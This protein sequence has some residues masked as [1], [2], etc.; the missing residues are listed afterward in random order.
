MTTDVVD[1]GDTENMAKSLLPVGL[2]SEK[3]L[4][5]LSYIICSFTVTEACKLAKV[6]HKTVECWRRDD[7]GFAE[8]E[9]K[10]RSE[11]RSRMS[12][13]LIDIEFTRNLKLVLAKDFKV[14]LKD[15]YGESLTEDEADYLKAIRKH[16]NPQQLASIKQLSSDMKPTD[17]QFNFTKTVFEITLRKTVESDS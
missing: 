5:Y 13:E 4:A 15:A 14:L 11:L 6:H 9:I 12:A 7:A 1:P 10:C 17:S 3:Q 2:G 16:Y 8:L